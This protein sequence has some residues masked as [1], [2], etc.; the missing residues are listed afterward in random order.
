M[1]NNNSN[2]NNNYTLTYTAAA[3]AAALN[4]LTTSTIA[5]EE[6]EDRNLQH[7]KRKYG[8]SPERVK[9]PP[10]A[11]LLFNRDMRRQLQDVHQ[12]LTSGEISKS[13]SARWK[14][15]SKNE[16]DYYFKEEAKLKQQHNNAY[17]NFVYT[18]R[19]KAEMREA[20]LQKKTSQP[21]TPKKQQQQ[22]GSTE[23]RKDP[24]G[25]KKKE[26]DHLPKHP[27]SAYLH[28]AKYMRPILKKEY[29]Q[30]KLVD[31]S[32]I[33]GSR[34]RAMIPEELQPWVE[35][36][37]QDKARYAREMKGRSAQTL[38]EL[39]SDTIATVAQMVNPQF[40]S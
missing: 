37:N 28:F 33:I 1:K 23:H 24:R 26:A 34:W 13:I 10:N 35:R 11:Y 4:S 39:D 14:N 22:L 31:I 17:T 15:L 30:G 8:Q 3:E 40:M 25:R 7:K 38:E 6:D 29:P 32:K 20:G 5:E 18:R 21:Q 19:S 36:A 16:R 27:M 12:G 9:R 2:N